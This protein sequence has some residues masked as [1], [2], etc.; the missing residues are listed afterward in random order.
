[1]AAGKRSSKLLDHGNHGSNRFEEIATLG[2]KMYGV[3]CTDE[4]ILT[5][6]SN[7]LTMFTYKYITPRFNYELDT[8]IALPK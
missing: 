7:G 1:M 5:K 6:L 3:L 4:Y 8:F 2:E